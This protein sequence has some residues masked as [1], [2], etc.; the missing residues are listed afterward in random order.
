M[1]VQLTLGT[2]TFKIIKGPPAS[3]VD[4][5]VT[6]TNGP[7]AVDAHQTSLAL[8]GVSTETS[9]L[10]GDN[11]EPL[12][13]FA[14]GESREVGNVVQLDPGIWQ[15]SVTIFDAQGNQVAQSDSHSV[16]IPG[17][18][19]HKEQFADSSQL[20]FTI[21]PTHVHKEEPTLVKVDYRLSCTG[22]VDI[23]PG[24]PVAITL[25]DSDG[26]VADQVYNIEQGVRRGASEPK[27][28]HV[29]CGESKAGDTAKLRMIGDHGGAA[30][31]EFKFTLTWKEDGT[32]EV[33]PA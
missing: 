27:F 15:V 28:L 12:N 33:T 7:E 30:E 18:Q 21:E 10:L 8:V 14:P 31:K 29:G 19:H 3:G 26:N 16:T 13:A 23:L 22:S 32:A 4:V 25:G 5:T 20:Q 2:P 24:F 6:V 11:A 1:A 9:Q 17:A